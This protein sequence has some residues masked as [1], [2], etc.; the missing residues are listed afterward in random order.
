MD[1]S[2]QIVEF[3]DEKTSQFVLTN[4]SRLRIEI[5]SE[6]PYLYDGDEESEREYLEK[7]YEMKDSL[8]IGAFDKENSIGGATAYPL[9][10]ESENLTQS[11]LDHGRAL[12]DYFCIGEIL[13]KKEYRNQGLGS[14]MCSK[15]EAFARNKGFP[16]ICFFEIDRGP[17][18]PKRPLDYQKL[19][20]Y[21]ERQGYRKHTELVGFIPYKELGDSFESPKKMIFWIKKLV[22]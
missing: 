6:Y 15:I 19:D 10:Y 20:P 8:A 5:F 21:W 7:F 11:F 13:L 1:E 12:K 9:V 2:I 18:D 17:E 16:N 3:S 22:S 4:I 14:R